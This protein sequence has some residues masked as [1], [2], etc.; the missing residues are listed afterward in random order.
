MSSH[1]LA[2]VLLGAIAL[3]L[4]VCVVAL[5]KGDARHRALGWSY[6]AFMGTSLVAILA[7]ARGHLRPFHGY[8]AVILGALIAAAWVPRL[9]ARIRAWRSLHAALM[10]LSILGA[11]IAVGGVLG[12]VLLG[13]ATG[14]AYYRMFD[15]I[16]V[17]FTAVGLAVIGTRPIIWGRTVREPD[18]RARAWFSSFVVAISLALVVAQLVVPTVSE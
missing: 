1:S 14:P 8:A 7:G 17:A 5:R 9:R 18:R 10:S 4:G 12:G 11:F 15:G 6:V 16:I 2:H 3:I 13:I